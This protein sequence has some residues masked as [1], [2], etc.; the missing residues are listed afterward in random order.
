AP[1]RTLSVAV[2]TTFSLRTLVTTALPAGVD[3]YRR[4]TVIIDWPYPS[5]THTITTSSLVYPIINT[6]YPSNN[7]SAEVTGGRITLSGCLGGD[8]FDDAYV[9]LPEVRADTS[10]STGALR[11]AIGGAGSAASHLGV[12]NRPD[13]SNCAA[14][15]VAAL[16]E[17]P[18]TT[19]GSIADNDSATLDPPT[20]PVS[21]PANVS[22]GTCNKTTAGGLTVV[23]PT[24]TLK[25]H[26]KTD[27]CTCTTSDGT[28][29]VDAVPWADASAATATGSSATTATGPVASLW[30]LGPVWSP[31]ASVD[32]DATGSGIVTASA[33]LDAPALSVL[34]FAEL[35]GGA[36]KVNAFTAKATAAS[37]YT[38]VG[39]ALTF[40]VAPTVQLSD[41]TATGYTTV[42]WVPG[43][44][45]DYTAPDRT[46]HT[47]TGYDVKFVSRV[48][49]QG[50]NPPTT[51]GT[52]P[53]TEALA[54]HPSFL[55]VTVAV[56]ITPS[57]LVTPTTT[58]TTT[59]V[60]TTGPATTIP[61]PPVATDSF[62][63]VVDYGQVSANATWVIA[64]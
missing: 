20:G 17:C 64:P 38:S 13:A 2:G 19:L 58:T 37:G 63:I 59:I 42:T 34:S 11:S 44:A 9:A 22:V 62:T 36:V 23:S 54:E 7:G 45:V 33:Q 18:R 35:P 53:R 15:A 43:T 28:A 55:R 12:S 26:A 1:Y 30:S 52:A 24:G 27:T 61:P 41:G 40:P 48:Q 21:A 5:P 16:Q 25:S 14:G 31:R 50:S 32:H 46:V 51:V 39:T 4:V 47:A 56:T 49:S 10:L 8:N 3:D 6:A 60:A 57:T 29:I